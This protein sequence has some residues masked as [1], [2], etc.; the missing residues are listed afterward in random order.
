M[1]DI[2]LELLNFEGHQQA[3]AGSV[4]KAVNRW[5]RLEDMVAAEKDPLALFLLTP[6]EDLEEQVKYCD[7][8][9]W[10]YLAYE[11]KLESFIEEEEGKATDFVNE[12]VARKQSEI[13]P[14]TSKFYTNAYATRLADI[15]RFP[16]EHRAVAMSAR[17]K[18]KLVK[19][20]IRA[21]ESKGRKL[22]GAQGTYNKKLLLEMNT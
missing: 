15:E 21:L 6:A 2:D 17:R 16:M 18:L 9:L 11:A 7:Y 5:Q 22:P 3:T 12:Y 10:R 8:L 4:P 1:D 20:Y 13:D 14:G 19:G